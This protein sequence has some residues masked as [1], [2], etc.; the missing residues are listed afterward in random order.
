MRWGH[1]PLRRSSAA[2]RG[3]TSDQLHVRLAPAQ[4]PV[5]L[6]PV[7]ALFNGMLVQ[8]ESSFAR[9]T[10]F[11]A[12]IAHELRTPVTSLATQTQVAL[13]KSRDAQ[14]Y[15][16]VLYSSLE[17]LERM[18]KMI[19][20]MLFLAQADNHLSKPE[21]QEVDL[22]DQ[23]RAL[24]D[25]F[26]AWAEE[27]G[28]RLQLEGQAHAV[29]GDPLMLRRA[30]SNLIANAPRHTPGGQTISVT[31]AAASDTVEVR[32]SNPGPDIPPQHLAHRFDRFYRVDPARRHEGGRAGLGLAIVKSI[33]QVHGGEVGVSSAHSTTSFLIRLPLLDRLALRLSDPGLS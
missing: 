14:A 6:D 10:H 5:E 25:Y 3:I 21:R 13:S 24:F 31:L 17:E 8:L 23:V 12:G 11:S 16:E 7:V 2:V 33:V 20:D 18:G 26:E 15:R 9:L 30:L 28:V 4:V 32:V 27:A 1:A 19:A 22:Q 29:L